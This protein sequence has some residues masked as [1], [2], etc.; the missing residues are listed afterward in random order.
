MHAD[1]DLKG[2]SCDCFDV[3]LACAGLVARIIVGVMVKYK[4]PTLG[5]DLD[6]ETSK[7]MH[8]VET[9]RIWGS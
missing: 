2:S 5:G 9:V 8:F 4:W 7:W 6:T 1:F 3:S